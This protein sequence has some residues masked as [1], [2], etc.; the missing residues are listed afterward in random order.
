MASPSSSPSWLS[1]SALAPALV[2]KLPDRV[3]DLP[4]SGGR[5]VLVDQGC[6]HGAVTH[7]MHLLAGSG[8]RIR[9]ELG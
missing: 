9:G 4:I 2:D 1:A 5:R 6:P 3:R 8:A 7:P